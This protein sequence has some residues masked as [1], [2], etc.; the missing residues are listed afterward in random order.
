MVAMVNIHVDDE[1][2]AE[3]CIDHMQPSAHRQERNTVR[4]RVGGQSEVRLVL[5]IV[6]VVERGIVVGQAVARRTHISAARQ[7]HAVEAGQP[8]CP[9]DPVRRRLRQQRDRIAAGQPHGLKQPTRRH[10]P[11]IAQSTR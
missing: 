2:P 7:E 3:K 5:Q 6:H 9:V 10:E 1:R 8:M 11:A 4:E